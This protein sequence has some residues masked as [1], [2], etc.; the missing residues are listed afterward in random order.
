MDWGRPPLVAGHPPNSGINSPINHTSETSQQAL[1]CESHNKMRN[2]RNLAQ[3]L[4]LDYLS[5]QLLITT[6]L[7]RKC[8]LI[9]PICFLQLQLHIYSVTMENF[10]KIEAK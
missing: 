2:L 9:V 10:V 4:T 7:Y 5:S 3:T 6:A 8:K 1:I